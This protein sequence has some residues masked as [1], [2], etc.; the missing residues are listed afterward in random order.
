MEY[1]INTPSNSKTEFPQFK[2]NEIYAHYNL[3]DANWTVI[4]SL[5][6][7]KGEAYGRVTNQP[8]YQSPTA[9]NLC[10]SKSLENFSQSSVL[11][12]AGLS[13]TLKFISDYAYANEFRVAV[14]DVPE[15]TY[16]SEKT[17]KITD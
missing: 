7:N 6:T 1:I 2:Q 9:G 5:S 12:I 11:H 17:D 13:N 4:P 15:P 3:P 10:K 8:T 16:K 14:D